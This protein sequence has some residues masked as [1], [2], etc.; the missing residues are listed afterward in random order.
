MYT[1][2][3][4]IRGGC[5]PS[6]QVSCESFLAAAAQQWRRGVCRVRALGFLNELLTNG[7]VSLAVDHLLAS[8]GAVLRQGPRVSD[9][10]C[11]G[12]AGKVREAFAEVMHAVV[13]LASKQPSAC[14]NTIAML[15]VVPYTR[16]G[17]KSTVV[18]AVSSVYHAAC[19]CIYL[20]TVN[21]EI[22]WWCF[23]NQPKILHIYEISIEMGTKIAL[24]SACRYFCSYFFFL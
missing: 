13:E 16:Y 17:R 22:Y 6:L 15:C 4:A 20:Y 23:K 24:F 5:F 19:T 21:T 1:C 7:Y 8:V 11:G 9:I 2:T 12:M 18:T 14:I 3:Y 10:A